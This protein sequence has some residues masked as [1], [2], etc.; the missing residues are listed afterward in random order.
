MN[1]EFHILSKKR[2]VTADFKGERSTS[3]G[4]IILLEAIERST[5]YLKGFCQKIFDKRLKNL[6]V[7]PVIKLVKQ[8]VYS[9]CLGYEDCNDVNHLKNDPAFQ[10]ILD[11]K[12][13]SLPTLSRF[14]NS[15][16]MSD[17]W[18]LSK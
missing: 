1:Y 17:I 2:G 10:H 7:R 13:A 18:R 14:E 15:L 5:S 11:G 8:R 4:S 12:L 3:D 16:R 6:V 9:I